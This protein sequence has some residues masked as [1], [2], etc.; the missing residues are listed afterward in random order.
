MRAIHI[1]TNMYSYQKGNKKK[2]KK[3]NKQAKN[4]TKRIKIHGF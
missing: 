1:K 3:T 4:N 2:R